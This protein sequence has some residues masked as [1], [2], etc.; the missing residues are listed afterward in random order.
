MAAFDEDRLER[1]PAHRLGEDL[2]TLSLDELD[3]R[4]A[5][6]RAEIVRIEDAI[7]QKRASAEAAEAF[8]KTTR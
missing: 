1:A 3:E 2:T 5:W 4:I 7:N 6:L 8:F